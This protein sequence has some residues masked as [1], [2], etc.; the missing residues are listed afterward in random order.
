MSFLNSSSAPSPV[1][2]DITTVFI[3]TTHDV[4]AG[5]EGLLRHHDPRFRQN[6][7]LLFTT[8]NILRVRQTCWEAKAHIQQGSAASLPNLLQNVTVGEL[9]RAGFL[10]LVCGYVYV[11]KR[12]ISPDLY[13]V[14]TCHKRTECAMRGCLHLDLI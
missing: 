12:N 11:L 13:P 6:L 4:H 9:R 5:N 7:H 1:S 3:S 14:R 8:Y 2:G 10:S